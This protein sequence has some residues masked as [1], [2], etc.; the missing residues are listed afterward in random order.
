MYKD[1]STNGYVYQK[2]LPYNISEKQSLN[3]IYAYL[4]GC[5]FDTD[6]LHEPDNAADKEELYNKLSK[7]L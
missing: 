5:G 1:I 6:L 3:T 4:I 7:L 2:D